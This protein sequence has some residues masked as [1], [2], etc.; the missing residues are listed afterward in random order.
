MNSQSTHKRKNY[1]YKILFNL[2]RGEAELTFRS[3]KKLSRTKATK[4]V[5]FIYKNL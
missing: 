5:N 2:Q 3:D 1:H 4:K